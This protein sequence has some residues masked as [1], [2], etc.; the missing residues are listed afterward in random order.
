EIPAGLS[1]KNII[2]I[3]TLLRSN[4]DL[5]D[6]IIQ[7]QKYCSSR[8]TPIAIATNGHQF[9]SFIASTQNGCSPLEGKALV[10]DSL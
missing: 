10:F 1:N 5:K 6:A 4:D 3:P 9:I 7:V 8:G 2:D